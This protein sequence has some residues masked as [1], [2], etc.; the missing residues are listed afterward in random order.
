MKDKEIWGKVNAIAKP[1]LKELAIGY[2]EPLAFMNDEQHLN[3]DW[4]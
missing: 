3:V 4:T 1:I 2:V